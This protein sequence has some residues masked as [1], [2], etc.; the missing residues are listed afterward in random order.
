MADGGRPGFETE[1][2]YYKST[3]EM[4]R[5]F[6]GFEGAVENTVKIAQMCNLEFEDKGY[7]LPTYPLREGENAADLLRLRTYEGIE[8]LM[9]AGRLPA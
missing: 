9:L 3:Q 4:E 8:R 2:F 6:G 7:L 5:L 1:E